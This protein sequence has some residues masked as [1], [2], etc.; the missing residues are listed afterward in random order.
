MRLRRGSYRR[1]A[2]ES[3]TASDVPPQL[4]LRGRGRG[5]SSASGPSRQQEAAQ[6]SSGRPRRIRGEDRTNDSSDRRTF[7]DSLLR[8]FAREVFQ[9]AGSSNF[10]E[11]RRRA[12]RLNADEAGHSRSRI[13]TLL[14]TAATVRA[15]A[16]LTEG[17]RGSIRRNHSDGEEEQ[18][19]DAA[20]PTIQTVLELLPG[21]PRGGATP[22]ISTRE[23]ARLERDR[24]NERRNRIMEAASFSPD[25][26]QEIASVFSAIRAPAAFIDLTDDLNDDSPL[27]APMAASISSESSSSTTTTSSSSDSSSQLASPLSAITSEEEA[28]NFVG[29]I[30]RR[31]S[32]NEE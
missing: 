7:N 31:A 13:P 22:E 23:R 29:A 4:A 18:V 11:R 24:R 20:R 26:E 5:T 1:A 3:S 30:G 9:D 12:V 6:S 17:R 14:A 10:S 25:I 28:I 21:P 27:A 2:G 19:S 32:S 15:R 8:H 16:I